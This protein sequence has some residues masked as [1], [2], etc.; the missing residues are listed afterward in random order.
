MTLENYLS[1]TIYVHYFIHFDVWNRQVDSFRFAPSFLIS[2]LWFSFSI[3][4]ASELKYYTAKKDKEKMIALKNEISTIETKMK[5]ITYDE[6]CLL[7]GA[8]VICT[9]LNSCCTLSR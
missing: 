7:E 3:Q 8:N 2:N 1:T 4:R 5:N 6:K 9:T